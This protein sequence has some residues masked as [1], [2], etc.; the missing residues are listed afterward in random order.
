M[1]EGNGRRY[2]AAMATP[3]AISHGP[4]NGVA[5]TAAALPRRRP[6]RRR[7]LFA[8]A[9]MAGIAAWLLFVPAPRAAIPWVM[10]RSSGWLLTEY[11]GSSSLPTRAARKLAGLWLQQG[12]AAHV[13]EA[14]PRPGS[15]DDAE[16]ILQ[17]LVSLKPKFISQT[18]LVHGPANSP[19]AVAG[20]GWCDGING[21]AATVLS[22]EFPRSEIVGVVDREQRGGHSFGRVWSEQY[23]DWLYFDLWTDEVAVFRSAPGRRAEML[24]RAR[25]LGPRRLALESPEVFQRMYDDAHSAFTQYRV[26]PTL[27]GY[28]FTRLANLVS[29]GSSA[30]EGADEAIAA[31]SAIT[32][33][34]DPDL[35]TPIRPEAGADY[36]QARFHHLL[37]HED[38]ARDAYR[39]VAAKERPP[40]SAY[41]RAARIFL[42]R[43]GPEA[44]AR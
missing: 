30:A 24:A 18:E 11:Q 12:L 13:H 23:R 26:Q 25:P 42:H 27:G 37:G 19:A 33:P 3:S 2:A 44:A 22:H 1:A 20:L 6:W 5:G 7:L 43:L 40:V 39:Q 14:Q 4:D 32:L 31:A 28:I 9:V 36:L 21:F 29:S 38:R 17:R 8:V 41:A 16:R 10:E 15:G 34:N 35:V